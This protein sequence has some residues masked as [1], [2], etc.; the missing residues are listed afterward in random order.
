MPIYSPA[1]SNYTLVDRFPQLN[2][3]GPR[4]TGGLSHIAESALSLL[5]SHTLPSSIQSPGSAVT[6]NP[7]PLPPKDMLQASSLNPGVLVSLNP[8][9][10]P[11]EPP[12]QSLWNTSA[13]LFGGGSQVG[14]L[15]PFYHGPTP[16]PAPWTA[17]GAWLR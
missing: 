6:I 7:Q 13:V 9:P 11:P 14:I 17:V 2:P 12:P 8:Q 16:D 10:L 1:L 4:E 3:G 15:P 5:T